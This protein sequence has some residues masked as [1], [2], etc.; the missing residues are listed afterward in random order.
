[1]LLFVII[2]I[3]KKSLALFLTVL[4]LLSSV[5]LLAG[6]ASGYTAKGD[7][8]QISDTEYKIAP[9][10]KENRIVVNK[11]SGTQQE[12]VYAVSVDTSVGATTGVMAGYADYKGDT[13]KM[14]T[15]RDQAKAAREKTGANIVAAF[16]ADIFN[17]ATGEPTGCLVM[18]GK[19][20]KAGLGRPYF[21]ITKDGNIVIGN[22][23]KQSVLDTLQEAVSGFYMIVQNGERVGPGTDHGSNIAPKTAVGIKEDGSLMVVAIDGRNYPISNSLDDFWAA[24]TV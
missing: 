11:T 18:G 20:Y 14:Q 13:F 4:M 15:V 22:S 16:N 12:V 8:Y 3:A 10:I 2:R 23:L 5:S 19:V 24:R 21:G 7:F 6:A 17:M 9:G 1:M